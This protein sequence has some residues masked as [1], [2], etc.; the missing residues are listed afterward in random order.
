MKRNR[1]KYILLTLL[2]IS[3]PLQVYAAGEAINWKKK[4]KQ[5]E[6]WQVY[7]IT[8]WNEMSGLKFTK[9][10]SY[11]KT[12]FTN[13][14]YM[15]VVEDA[16]K[17]CTK[18][19]QYEPVDYKNL[20]VTM[21]Q[22]MQVSTNTAGTSPTDIACIRYYLDKDANITD[23]KESVKL[24]YERICECESAYNVANPTKPCDIYQNNAQLKGMIQSVIYSG[25]NKKYTKKSA[26]KYYQDN[27]KNS[28]DIYWQLSPYDEFAE[29]VCKSY[30]TVKASENSHVIVG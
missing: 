1:L 20:I 8:S 14:A 21:I 17:E 10:G 23:P 18:K 19:G 16:L 9:D 28:T 6:A 25:Y 29:D 12:E 13:S 27:L 24:L 11:S 30:K 3:I 4:A 7:L 2:V 22:Y 26:K 15:K 5:D